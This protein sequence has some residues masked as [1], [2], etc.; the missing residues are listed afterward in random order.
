MM[1]AFALFFCP[2][3]LP[4]LA[5]AL[6]NLQQRHVYVRGVS[7]QVGINGAD[8]VALFNLYGHPGVCHIL[9]ARDVARNRVYSGYLESFSDNN[10]CKYAWGIMQLDRNVGLGLRLVNSLSTVIRNNP[11]RFINGPHQNNVLCS[12]T[13]YLCI[14]PQPQWGTASA[15]SMYINIQMKRIY[16]VNDNGDVTGTSQ[17]TDFEFDDYHVV[18]IFVDSEWSGA[19]MHIPKVHEIF[20]DELCNG[21]GEGEFLGLGEP[22]GQGGGLESLSGRGGPCVDLDGHPS[23]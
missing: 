17:Y 9:N 14:S 7:S 1:V 5:D 22:G 11:F 4:H 20:S 2:F 3:I 18:G 15:C 19:D 6:S 21:A 10:P 16:H 12:D 23:A 8:E 13:Y